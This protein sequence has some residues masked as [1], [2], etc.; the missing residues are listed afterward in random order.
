MNDGTDLETLV[1]RIE[2]L[3]APQGIKVTNREA[4]R[5]KNGVQIAELDIFIHGSVGS[6]SISWLVECRDRPSSG[7]A[8]VSW[9]EQ[10][11]ARRDR[12]NLDKVIAV[13]TTGFSQPAVNFAR[14]KGVLTRTVS[15][16]SE[17]ADDMFVQ[18]IRWV[19]F[20]IQVTGDCACRASITGD[21]LLF[22][23]QNIPAVRLV[24]EED[25]YG[26]LCELI[27][28]FWSNDLAWERGWSTSKFA[29]EAPNDHYLISIQ[30]EDEVTIDQ[31]TCPISLQ[32]T[33]IDAAVPLMSIYEE[34]GREIARETVFRLPTDEGDIVVRLNGAFDPNKGK[35]M[36]TYRYPEE[37]PLAYSRH[38]MVIRPTESEEGWVEFPVD[39]LHFTALRADV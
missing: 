18:Q 5:D 34:E 35:W 2:R 4:I 24:A 38:V 25:E 17:F 20:E 11:V 21:Q 39:T 33:I 30:E 15:R 9:I 26:T 36:L 8:P 37:I 32:Y 3:L 31:I 13:S 12:L 22:S 7:R 19:L 14:E 1:A 29:W 23:P 28:R 10:L 6:S 16:L 27:W